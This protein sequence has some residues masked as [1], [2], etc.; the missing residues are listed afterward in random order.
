MNS[1][2]DD[3]RAVAAEAR[4]IAYAA[5]RLS[6]APPAR[7]PSRRMARSIHRR[8]AGLA[9]ALLAVSQSRRDTTH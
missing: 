2:H 1:Y 6:E 7:A 4:A 9:R 5:R 3:W 8:L